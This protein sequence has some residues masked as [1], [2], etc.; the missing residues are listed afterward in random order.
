MCL[1]D[2]AVVGWPA[3]VAR[4]LQEVEWVFAKTYAKT[5]PHEYIVRDRV[6]RELFLATVN[7]IRAHGYE[8]RFYRRRIIYF[9]DGDL[10]YWT[11]VPPGGDPG[12]YPPEEETIVN[13]CPVEST[14]EYRLEHG[15]LP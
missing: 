4:F 3:L 5:W 13:R 11:M 1:S 10:V 9:R 7:H 12:W 6:D 14:Y 2:P 8:G 15:M